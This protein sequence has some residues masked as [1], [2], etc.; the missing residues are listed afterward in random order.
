[1]TAPNPHAFALDVTRTLKRLRSLGTVLGHEYAVL[2]DAAHDLTVRGGEKVMT[3]SDSTPTESIVLAR[4]SQRR[5]LERAFKT[6]TNTED[7]WR[8]AVRIV[9]LALESLDDEPHAPDRQWSGSEL[10]EAERR[11]WEKRRRGA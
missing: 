2:H 6:I 10:A 8:E 4:S 7:Q 5:A 3:G 11:A 1:M 9:Q